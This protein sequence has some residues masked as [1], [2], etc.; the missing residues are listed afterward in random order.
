M[1]LTPVKNRLRG[2]GEELA[3]GTEFNLV[4][5]WSGWSCRTPLR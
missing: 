1:A 4:R 5:R 2:D 3:V